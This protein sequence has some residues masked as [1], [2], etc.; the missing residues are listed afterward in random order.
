MLLNIQL[1]MTRGAALPIHA[2]AYLNKI[3]TRAYYWKVRQLSIHR[4]RQNFIPEQGVTSCF[5]CLLS[6]HKFFAFKFLTKAEY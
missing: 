1:V 3:V 2:T 6:I 5:Q 4:V